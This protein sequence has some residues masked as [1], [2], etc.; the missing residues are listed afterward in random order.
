MPGWRLAASPS[1]PV[2]ASRI[3]DQPDGQ[4]MHRQSS[5][6]LGGDLLAPPVQTARNLSA[7]NGHQH[8]HDGV[9][10]T[11]NGFNCYCCERPTAS[12]NG[13]HVIIVVS[14]CD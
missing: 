6:V 14:C 10:G 2:A 5:P 1:S 7:P 8:N 11:A 12:A 9:A 4:S 3:G 13:R